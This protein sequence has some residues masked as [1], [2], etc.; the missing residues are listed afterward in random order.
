MSLLRALPVQ[1]RLSTHRRYTTATFSTSELYSPY[2]RS[3]LLG[4]AQASA[5]YHVRSTKAPVLAIRG[6][7][8][9]SGSKPFP[10]TFRNGNVL[11]AS[12][13]SGRWSDTQSRQRFSVK[14]A[15]ATDVQEETHEY[16]A[17]VP[18]GSLSL[19]RNVD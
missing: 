10:A 16:Q 14:S 2:A 1:V 8:Q 11:R 4:S 3:D 7:T 9:L 18:T 19:H 6:L 13:A 15:A 17:E 12:L 5:T